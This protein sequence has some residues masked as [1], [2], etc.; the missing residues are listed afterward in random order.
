MKIQYAKMIVLLLT[1]FYTGNRLNAQDENAGERLSTQLKNNRVPGW[2]Y[3]GTEPA[4]TSASVNKEN[5]RESLAVQIRKGIAPGMKFLPT[6]SANTTAHRPPKTSA[7]AA[8]LAS[9]QMQ[10]HVTDP[11]IKVIP[12]PTQEEQEREL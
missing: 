10:K 7:K 9:E 1:V 4:K 11:P 8:P 2:Q 3:T 6:S 5:N 12:V